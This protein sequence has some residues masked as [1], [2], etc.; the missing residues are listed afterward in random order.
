MVFALVIVRWVHWTACLLLAASQLCPFWLLPETGPGEGSSF[1]CWRNECLSRLGKLGRATW[2]FALFSLVLWFGLTVWEMAGT[3]GEVDLA[4]L[5]AVASQTQFGRV[6]LARLAVLAVA[7]LCLFFSRGEPAAGAD[8]PWTAAANGLAFG[9]LLTLA[10]IG[11]AAAAPGSAAALFRFSIDALH[12]AAASVWPG[13]LV[14][15]AVLLRCAMQSRPLPLVTVVSRATDRFSTL[16]LAAVAALS[17]TGLAMSCCFLHRVHE[18]WTSA[19]GR[20]LTAKV[21]V[22]FGMLAIG[23]SN[24]LVLRR[25]LGRQ[26]RTERSS[27]SASTARALFRNV[28]WEIALAAFV[29]LIVAALGLSGPPARSH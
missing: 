12:L 25:K 14:C 20:L 26:P 3:D 13:G 7:G 2:G 9:N 29:L 4:A 28:V 10:L 15:F 6:I 1:R 24:L 11:H 17:G 19:Y 21:L 18:L 5:G 8:R 27:Q 22:F 23:A 16:S